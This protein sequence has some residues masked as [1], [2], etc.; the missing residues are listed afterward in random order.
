MRDLTQ[1]EVLTQKGPACGTTSL[2]MVIRF[3]TQDNGITPEAID[4]EIRKLPGM[5]SAP[6]D[7][8]GYARKK[9]LQAEEYNHY[10]I[11]QIRDLV[12][13]GIPVMPLL[14]LTPDNALDFKHW[15]WVV[16]VAIQGTNGHEIVIVNNPWGRQEKLYRKKFL[17]EWAHLKLLGLTFGY[18]NYAI[19]IGTKDDSLPP[20][21]AEGVGPGNAVTKGIAD[22]MNG[23]ARV[24]RSYSFLGFS[25]MLWGILR[26]IFG[27]GYL[28]WSNISSWV[29]CILASR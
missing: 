7:L 15:H 8:V 1:M 26:S 9:G 6:I 18:S 12:T 4:S 22:I 11:Q 23:F 2:A 19:A 29:G 20:R 5:F 24:R 27:A 10:S 16:V 25:Q 3:L 14:E 17:K 13:R 28:V 21:H